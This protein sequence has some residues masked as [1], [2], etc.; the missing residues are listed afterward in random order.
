MAA[1]LLAA[2]LVSR[3][4]RIRLLANT[5][6]I[7]GDARVRAVR[8]ETGEEIPADLLVVA[9]GIRPNID[10]PRAAGLTCRRGVL[11]DDTLQSFDASIYAVGECAE[12][13]QA[14]YGLVA[15]LWEQAR[16]CAAH[17]AGVG[18]LRYGGSLAAAQLKV[19]G[20]DAYSAG[21]VSESPGN[22][23][24][25]YTD[26]KRGIY[27]RLVLNGNRLR[28]AVLYGDASD[29]AFYL[30]LIAAGRSIGTE[31]H[32]LVFDVSRIGTAA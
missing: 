3:G 27:K 4:I 17:L 10:L 23:T 16:V 14:V 29:G 19:S 21:D 1:R 7:L 5:T 8:L 22:E 24:L 13:R 32:D 31:R 25:L 18:V 11:V 30:D 15:P 20:I 6:A 28:G 9:A 12:H 2:E 26:R